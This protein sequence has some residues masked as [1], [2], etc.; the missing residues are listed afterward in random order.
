MKEEIY[1]LKYNIT[2]LFFFTVTSWAGLF[3]FVYLLVG[4]QKVNIPHTGEV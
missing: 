2:V 4:F 3:G 1:F